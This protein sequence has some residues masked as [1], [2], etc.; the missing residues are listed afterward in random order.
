[1]V[2]ADQ[3]IYAQKHIDLSYKNDI[4]TRCKYLEK[5]TEE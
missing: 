3:I 4:I 2:K 5:S 1:M